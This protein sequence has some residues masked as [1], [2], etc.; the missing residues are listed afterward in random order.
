MNFDTK[1]LLLEKLKSS[2][3]Q[4]IPDR[5]VLLVTTKRFSAGK[6]IDLFAI[7][8]NAPT[9]DPYNVQAYIKLIEAVKTTEKQVV[10]EN[11]INIVDF[12]TFRIEHY[13][14]KLMHLGKNGA[15]IRL[16]MLVYPTIAQFLSWENHSIISSICSN[17]TLLYGH[18][19][20]FD[21]INA[22]TTEDSFEQR[23]QPLVSLMFETYRNIVCYA[24][25]PQET[26]RVLLSEGLNK[27]EYVIR[28]IL[29]ELLR[30]YTQEIPSPETDEIL[31]SAKGKNVGV[32]L[33]ELLE[34]VRKLKEAENTL[35][36]V[37]ILYELSM[38]RVSMLVSNIRGNE[39]NVHP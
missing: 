35:S 34:K 20:V 12:S 6:D 31:H 11:R 5:L 3:L 15:D 18:K 14:C 36:D 29:W 22:S 39:K 16:H 4:K 9:N 19:D 2:I 30:E 27:L 17:Y 10:K 23:I 24:P 8:D 26:E 1:T 28:F 32:N 37:K 7:L 13:H 33:T 25:V 21:K 38:S